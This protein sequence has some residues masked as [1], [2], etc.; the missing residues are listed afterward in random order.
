MNDILFT[1]TIT[2]ALLS[3]CYLLAYL[4]VSALRYYA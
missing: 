2:G 3:L 4:L 1:A